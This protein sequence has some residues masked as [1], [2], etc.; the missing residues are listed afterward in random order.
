MDRRLAP[1]TTCL[2]L[3]L[4]ISLLILRVSQGGYNF[5]LFATVPMVDPFQG[6]SRL[7]CRSLFWLPA[8]FST[9][10]RHLN[11]HARSGYRRYFN[12]HFDGHAQRVIFRFRV[13][14][15][16]HGRIL[17]FAH[18]NNAGHDKN[19]KTFPRW[20]PRNI[21]VVASRLRGYKSQNTSRAPTFNSALAHLTRRLT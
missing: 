15:G 3:S 11:A 18:G 10:I 4:L 7:R 20:W 17:G 6:R 16:F 21:E 5:L 8:L 1:T 13:I 9:S 12:L 14:H 2:C 19:T